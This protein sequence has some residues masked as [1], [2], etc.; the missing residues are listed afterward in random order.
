[1]KTTRRLSLTDLGENHLEFLDQW[2]VPNLALRLRGNKDQPAVHVWPGRFV[3]GETVVIAA[4][5]NSRFE[6]YKGSLYVGVVNEDVTRQLQLAGSTML[7]AY[8]DQA[9]NNVK[10]LV[11]AIDL[12]IA[13]KGLPVEPEVSALAPAEP[14]L[15][16]GHGRL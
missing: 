11:G 6:S 1:M 9:P 12:L 5:H 8:V 4:H 2:K 16:V 7:E 15:S 3:V 10:G 13:I 14:P